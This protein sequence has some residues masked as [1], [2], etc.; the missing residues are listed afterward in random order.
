M[1]V[2]IPDGSLEEGT[3]VLVIELEYLK[4]TG[5]QKRRGYLLAVN[6]V[7]VQM[8]WFFLTDF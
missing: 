3:E 4:H 1:V 7:C 2:V 5:M 8:K 6:S